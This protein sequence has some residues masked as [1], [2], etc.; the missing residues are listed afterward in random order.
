MERLFLRWDH[1]HGHKGGGH[2]DLI[3]TN[4]LLFSLFS[5][6]HAYRIH[7]IDVRTTNYQH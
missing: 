3:T 7:D 4:P 2:R 1:F 6:S 5:S